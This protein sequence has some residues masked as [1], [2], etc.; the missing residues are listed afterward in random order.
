M[1]LCRYVMEFSAVSNYVA[2]ISASLFNEIM[3]IRRIIS[4]AGRYILSRRNL[5]GLTTLKTTLGRITNMIS[6]RCLLGKTL[7][8]QIFKFRVPIIKITDW[9]LVSIKYMTRFVW[10]FLLYWA[11]Q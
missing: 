9:K 7:R 4:I 2:S 11:D 5:G 1:I 8:Y 3:T 10:S 6:P